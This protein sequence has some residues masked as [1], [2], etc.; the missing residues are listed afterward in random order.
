M[1]F[2]LFFDSGTFVSWGV[3]A[4]EF[5]IDGGKFKPIVSTVLLAT[6]TSHTLQERQS[7]LIAALSKPPSLEYRLL[8]AQLP[9]SIDHTPWGSTPQQET[10]QPAPANSPS[11]GLPSF[12]KLQR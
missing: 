1:N 3:I 8:T 5:I 4:N 7:H 11:L 10:Q 6:T 2:Y 9:R 12:S